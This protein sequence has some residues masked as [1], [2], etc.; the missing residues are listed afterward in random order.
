M[1]FDHWGKRYLW[2]NPFVTINNKNAIW[3]TNVRPTNFPK[4][5]KN[6]FATGKSFTILSLQCHFIENSIFETKLASFSKSIALS[7][8]KT[9]LKKLKLV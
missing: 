5:L 8:K 3:R 2:V 6:G 7:L 4:D 9:Y 1:F